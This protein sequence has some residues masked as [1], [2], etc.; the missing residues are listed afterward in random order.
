MQA[1]Q[2]NTFNLVYL[3]TFS[4]VF[5]AILIYSIGFLAYTPYSG[6]D[7]NPRT[8]GNIQVFDPLQENVFQPDDQ[9]TKINH[10]S[11]EEFQKDL[12]A[13]FWGNTQIGDTIDIEI[14]R[15]GERSSVN[16]RFTGRTEAEVNHRTLTFWPLGIAD[17][18]L[19]LGFFLGLEPGHD[20]RRLISIGILLVAFWIILIAGPVNYHLWFSPY[21][22]TFFGWIIV[23][24]LLITHWRFPTA[25]KSTSS[26]IDTTVFPVIY[27]L[28]GIG[29]IADFLIPE[30]SLFF[31]GIKISAFISTILLIAH[32]IIQEENRPRLNIIAKLF[33]IAI[34]PSLTII[35]LN[36]FNLTL[37]EHANFA[38]YLA[39]PLIPTGYLFALWHNSDKRHVRIANRL[40]AAYIFIVLII[41]I[42]LSIVDLL[43]LT[44]KDIDSV[45]ILSLMGLIGLIASL[46]FNPFQRMIGKYILDVLVAVPDVLDSYKDIL[47]NTQDTASISSLMGSL[48]IPALR[49]RQSAL[50]EIQSGQVI[51]VLD[52]RGLLEDQIPD[53]EEIH[54]LIKLNKTILPHLNLR[55]LQP[56]KRWVRVFLPLKFDQELIGVWLLGRRDPNDY[57]EDQTVQAL[58]TIA[59]QTTIAIINH[60]KS[61]RIRSL[62]EANIN[63]NEVE[64][65]NLA[66]ELHDD[67]LN[68]LAVLQREFNDPQLIGS[69]RNI[70]NS[71]RKTIQG[72]RPEMLSYGLITALQDLADM[73]NERNECP[74]V[75]VELQGK[76]IALNHNTELHIFRIMQ[77]ACENAIE[78]A[79]ANLIKIEGEIR[80]QSIHLRVVDDGVGILE[81]MPLNLTALIQNQHFG[82]AGMFERANIINAKLSVNSDPGNG[83]EIVLNW[84]N[85][86]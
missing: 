11:L 10:L 24:M 65:A 63:R 23:A 28:S 78:H 81:K 83:T 75:T 19:S 61:I 9:I 76:P 55:F 80:E 69:L 56:Q 77:Q 7:F 85:Q 57:Y 74:T 82:L 34:L 43:E 20:H 71:L 3:L 49:I 1:A 66:R 6:F 8:G 60:Q 64:R 2:K 38:V 62:Y 17:V 15:N 31:T 41:L 22:A 30:I 47:Q 72:L 37:D 21:I 50:I 48:I 39:I 45:E 46:G 67:A 26:W 52:I 40:L 5:A 51:R 36:S 33:A 25:F 68:N 14:M 58:E 12:T 35:T 70:I 53:T 42:S 44:Q 59:R 73:L 13:S 79:Q 27:F 29:M 86:D 4:A 54:Q 32:Y 84:P 18:V 16:W